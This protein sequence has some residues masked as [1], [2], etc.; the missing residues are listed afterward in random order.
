MSVETFEMPSSAAEIISVTASAEEHFRKQV[1]RSSAAA[2]RLSMKESGCT[3]YKYE[4]SEV[5]DL[6]AEV[7]ASDLK[8][9][10]HNKIDLFLDVKYAAALKGTVIDYRQEGLN[11]NLVLENPNV[12]DACGCG[13][14]FSV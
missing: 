8:M 2:I 4:I 1:E 6:E 14:S 10:L 11:R 12:K 3:G 13:E 9:T 7:E 5:R